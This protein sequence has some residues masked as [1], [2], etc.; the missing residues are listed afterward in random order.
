L[1]TAVPTAIATCVDVR[2]TDSIASGISFLLIANLL[3]RGIGFARNIAV[4]YF[5]TEQQLGMWGLA[6]G[7]FFLAAPLAVLG[8]PGSFGR[9]VESYRRRNQL[10]AFVG[11]LMAVSMLGFLTMAAL[12]VI[13]PA[14][15]GQLIFGASQSVGTMLALAM[16]LGCIILFNASTELVTGLRLP[17]TVSAMHAV[18][19]LTLTVTSLVGLLCVRDWRILIVA[20]GFSA[21]C[22]IAPGLKACWNASRSTPS[23]SDSFSVRELW[24]RIVPFAATLWVINLT[25]NAFDVVDRYM[26]LHF[27]SEDGSNVAGQAIVGQLHSGKLIPTLLASLAAMLAG[28]LLPYMVADWESNRRDLVQ[29]SLRLTLKLGALFFFALS[30]ASLLIAPLLFQTLLA[31]RYSDGLMI[32]PYALLVCCWLAMSTL[33]NNYFWCA[34]QGRLL[35]ALTALALVANILLNAMMIPRLGMQGAMIANCI[36]CAGLLLLQARCLRGQGIS[37]G[38]DTLLICMSPMSLVFGIVPAGL[39]GVLVVL[40]AMQRDW[41]FSASEKQTIYHAVA[42]MLHK[43]SR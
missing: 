3:Q 19:S 2:P 15:S 42:P 40:L 34:E 41:L 37:L 24:K 10:K 33:L 1:S 27:A 8:L 25:L 5:L 20:F 30:I 14:A 39:V 32:L 6:S 21:L 31:G 38:W 9:F 28:M 23:P 29:K 26:L 4:C 35:G 36:S 16:A 18:N 13:F 22:G 11:W 43:F 7:F 17:R 12:L